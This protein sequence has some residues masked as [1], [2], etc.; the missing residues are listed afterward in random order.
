MIKLERTSESSSELLKNLYSMY[1]HDLSSYTSSLQINSQGIFEFDGF[2]FF[3][4]KEGI[5]PY[6][7]MYDEKIVGFLLLLSA[8]FTK[9]RI[10]YSIND[11]FILKGYRGKEVARRAVE[12]CFKEC[13]GIYYISQLK[14]NKQAVSF[15]RK[16]YQILNLAYKEYEDV[17]D[18]EAV[19]IQE[20]IVK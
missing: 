4:K 8:S 11:F 13:K 14:A 3:W 7:I 1:L 19:I 18:D 16:T 15:W 17:V 12:A 6:F 9:D 20:V 5:Q 2:D 10:D